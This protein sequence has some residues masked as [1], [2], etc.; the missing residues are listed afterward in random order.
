MSQINRLTLIL[1]AIFTYSFSFAQIKYEDLKIDTTITGFRFSGDI[2]GAKFF[3][4]NGPPDLTSQNPSV[5]SILI[6][7]NMSL[8]EGKQQLEN[9]LGESIESGYEISNLIRKDTTLNGYSAFYISYEE[10]LEEEGYHSIYFSAVVV[11]DETIIFFA[12]GDINNG[13]YIEKFKKTF[14]SISI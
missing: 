14:F 1:L 12:S 4:K 5:F 7:Q 3:S 9:F 13:I 11:K 2:E 10:N 8:N 6:G